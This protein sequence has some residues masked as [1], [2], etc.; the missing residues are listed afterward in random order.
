MNRTVRLLMFILLIGMILPVSCKAVKQSASASDTVWLQTDPVQCLGNPWE[1][2]W[3]E[4]HDGEYEAYPIGNP[5]EVEAKEA[6]VIRSFFEKQGIA[7]LEVESKPYPEGAMV[8]DACSCPQGYTLYLQVREK[9]MEA[10]KQFDF[11]LSE[12]DH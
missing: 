7:I 8:C 4:A 6:E 3:L 2:A 1:K 12:E 9:D 11:K 10:L 5:R